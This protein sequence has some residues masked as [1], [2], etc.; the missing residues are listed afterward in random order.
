MITT[1]TEDESS[2]LVHT[3]TW[4]DVR[5][6]PRLN[7]VMESKVWLEAQPDNVVSSLDQLFRKISATGKISNEQQFR[8]LSDGIWE[9]KRGAQRLL[10]FQHG[11]FWSLTD[12]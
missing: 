2:D 8:H 11:K 12:Y 9:F 5:H 6:A 4:G 1:A 10:C 7:G 3:G